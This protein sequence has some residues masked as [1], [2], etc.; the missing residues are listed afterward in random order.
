MAYAGNIQIC[1]WS[2][3]GIIGKSSSRSLS[4]GKHGDPAPEVRFVL[5][6][7]QNDQG[8]D[9]LPPPGPQSRLTLYKSAFVDSLWGQEMYSS[10]KGSH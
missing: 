3:T 9:M 4:G 8:L 1:D 2:Y 10:S 5:T 6:V 7:T